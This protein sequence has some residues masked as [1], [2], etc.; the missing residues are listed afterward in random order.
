MPWSQTKHYRHPFASFLDFM[1][2]ND[3]S[4]T[5]L[6]NMMWTGTCKKVFFLLLEYYF[7]ILMLL[8]KN[9]KNNNMNV[10]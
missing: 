10:N 4:Y 5:V 9:N 2:A 7:N 6:D 1:Y 3:S 8:L